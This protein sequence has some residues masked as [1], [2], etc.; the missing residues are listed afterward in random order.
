MSSLKKIMADKYPRMKSS[1]PTTSSTNYNNPI[2]L[3]CIIG[4]TCFVA[5]SC[6]H[7]T[8][9]GKVKHHYNL[10]FSIILAIIA[11]MIIKNKLN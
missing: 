4:I 5:L 9:G 3:S 2:I 6:L 11:Y 1:A 8:S 10:L 7:A